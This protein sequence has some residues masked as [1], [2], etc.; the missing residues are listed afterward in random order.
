MKPQREGGGNLLYKEK[1]VEAL[2]TMD[3]EERSAYVLMDRICPPSE[4][5]YFFTKGIVTI[6]PGKWQRG[7]S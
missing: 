1:M 5:T 2:T 4:E 3:E 7:P 6:L